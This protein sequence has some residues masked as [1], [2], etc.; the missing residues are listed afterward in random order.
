MATKLNIGSGQRRFDTSKGWVNIDC[1][2]REGQV[3]DVICDVGRECLPYGEC[4]VDICVLHHVLEH[5]GC[6]EGESLI[7]ECFRVL[8]PGGRLCVYVPNMVSLANAWIHGKVTDFIFMVNTYG[9][10][11]GEDGDR[12]RW[13]YSSAS[14][15]EF[16]SKSAG[17]RHV[18][19]TEW[20]PMDGA[21]IAQDW[22]ILGVE[23]VK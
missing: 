6:G 3:P 8:R 15:Q 10:Y 23:C 22:W 2:S 7:K 14:L 21:D 12:H 11:Q 1:V 4:T 16:L 20:Q 13:G 18:H 17:W 9:A 19:I 5:F